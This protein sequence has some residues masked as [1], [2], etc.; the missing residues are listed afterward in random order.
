MGKAKGRGY[1]LVSAE[2]FEEAEDPFPTESVAPV[3][4]GSKGLIGVYCYSDVILENELGQYLSHIPPECVS[5][6]LELEKG[7]CFWKNDVFRG[8]NVKRKMPLPKRGA[9]R[10]GSV[11]VYRVADPAR[12]DPARLPRSIGLLQNAGFGKLVYNHKQALED[13]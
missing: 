6:G 12:F 4:V 13:F 3:A 9:I 1:G 8:F 7:L 10:A 2:V 5:E 11:M